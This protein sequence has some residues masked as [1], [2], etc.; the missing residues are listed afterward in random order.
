MKAIYVRPSVG[1]IKLNV[2]TVMAQ[3][4]AAGFLGP[5]LIIQQ[6]DAGVAIPGKWRLLYSPTGLVNLYARLS[7][8]GVS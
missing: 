6:D 7:N 8:G 5:Y 3:G 2:R 1:A 4:V